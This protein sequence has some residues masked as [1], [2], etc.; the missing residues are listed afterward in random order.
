[1]L[2]PAALA[3][4]T[5]TP[6]RINSFKGALRALGN[7]VVVHDESTMT[8][9]GAS[10]FFDDNAIV[11]DARALS[12]ELAERIGVL[13]RIFRIPVVDT[14]GERIAPPAAAKKP[15]LKAVS[16]LQAKETI[17]DD[18]ITTCSL[19]DRTTP[20]TGRIRI[21]NVDVTIELSYNVVRLAFRALPP[22]DVR[23]LLGGALIQITR[24]T[25]QIGLGT[26]VSLPAAAPDWLAR[27][28]A[29]LGWHVEGAA[30]IAFSRP[31]RGR[32]RFIHPTL[33]SIAAHAGP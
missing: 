13:S 10:F 7:D 4:A 15:M 33:E 31:T 6:E 21:R 27:T 32:R 9:A 2:S 19:V 3:P 17:V 1:M 25:D 30:G 14:N 18:I 11:V 20:T 5:L 23:V 12:G 22:A 28:F 16:L 8:I 26:R 24:V 29:L